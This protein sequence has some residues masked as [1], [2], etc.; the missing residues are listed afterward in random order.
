MNNQGQIIIT[1]IL[2]Y[3]IVLTLILGAI[4]YTTATINDNQVTRINNK[5]LNNLVDTTMNT[6]I[7]TSGNPSNWEDLS[8]NNIKNIGLKSQNGNFLSYDKIKRLK[9]NPQIL[10]TFFPEN[11][12]YSITIYPKNNQ[13]NKQLIAGKSYLTNRKQIQS[14]TSLFFIDYGYDILSISSNTTEYCPYNHDSNWNCR[15][16]TINQALLNEGKYYIVTESKTNYMLSNTFSQ[17]ITGQTDNKRCINDDLGQLYQS[18]NETIY[19]HTY[20]NNNNSYLV[21]DKKDR[22]EYLD[23][24]IRPE[25]YLLDLKIAI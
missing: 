3:L 21:Y 5:E 7:K 11:V 25:V 18:E 20:I 13:N 23:S 6:L 24:V 19:V 14:K 8:N 9:N 12:E 16:F 4:V 22:E 1:D 10:N 2:L 17:N 15:V